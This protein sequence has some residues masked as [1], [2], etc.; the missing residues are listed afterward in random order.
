[1]LH[2]DDFIEDERTIRVNQ[3]RPPLRWIANILGSLASSAI[4]RISFAEEEGRENTLSY[5]K[6]LFI[7][8]RCWGIYQKYGTFYQLKP[9]E[10][11][12]HM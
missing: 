9:K 11:P 3:S 8:D 12:W 7:W 4:L 1:M 2:E 5:K 10:D 6:D